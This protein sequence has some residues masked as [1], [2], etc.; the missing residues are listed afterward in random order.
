MTPLLRAFE[1]VLDYLVEEQQDMLNDS[2]G[3][4]TSHD[5]R[6][7]ADAMAHVEWLTGQMLILKEELEKA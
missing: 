6:V 5:L 7:A 1:M 4:L 2:T 3:S